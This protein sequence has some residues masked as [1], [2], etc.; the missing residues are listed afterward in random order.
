[1]QVADTMSA[2][3]DVEQVAFSYPAPLGGTVNSSR[4]GADS[5]SLVIAKLHVDPAFLSLLEIPLIS[6]RPFEPAD[7]Q[8]VVIISRRVAMT[9]YGTL[10]VV[11][12][13]YPRSKGTRT[14]VGVAGDATVLE[15]RASNTA[16]EYMPLGR[17]H[18]QDAVLLAKSRSNP[19]GLVAPLRAAAKRADPRVF[20][21]TRLLINEYETKLR[22]PRLASAIAGGVA[23]L[24]LTLACLGIFGVVAYAVKLRTKEIGIRRALGADGTQVVRVLLRQLAWPVGMGMA[25]GSAAGMAASRLLGGAPFYLALTEAR[26]P[27]AALSVFIA[28]GLAAALV[29]AMRALRADPLAALR[30]E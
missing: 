14:I 12:K 7:D 28:A 27:A 24:V 5:G 9:M 22:G 10:D 1:L 17:Q 20:P 2:H 11:G 23:G 6:G 21:D 30:H 16:E 26:V 15:P 29:P 4:Y 8:S 18:Y 3:P 19:R 13:Q 25:I